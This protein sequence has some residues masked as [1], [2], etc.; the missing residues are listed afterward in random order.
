VDCAGTSGGT[1]N[2]LFDA[3]MRALDPAESVTITVTVSSEAVADTNDENNTGSI[4][5]TR[6]GAG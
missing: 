2:G 5:L 1:W 3:D 4:T 6:T